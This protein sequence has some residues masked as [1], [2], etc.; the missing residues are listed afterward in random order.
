M[1]MMS[2]PS[3]P[4]RE[5][6]RN[7]GENPGGSLSSPFRVSGL[8]EFELGS[9][10]S[11]SASAST[12]DSTLTEF[13]DRWQRGER[14]SAED[15]F[16]RLD[17][18]KDSEF[19]ELIYRE[20]C[21]A[22]SAGLEPDVLSFL[23]RFPAYCKPLNQLFSVHDAL[24]SSDLQSWFEPVPMPEVGC[25]LGPYLLVRELG[26]GGFARVFLAE[27]TD[28]DDRLVV[29][30]ISSRPSLEHKLLARSSH[31]NIVEVLWHGEV[32]NYPPPGHLHAVPGR[33][34]TV[35]PARRSEERNAAR[36][37]DGSLL[38]DLDRLSITG[39]Q[40]ASSARPS[41]RLI[42]GLSY[43]KSIGW[44][45]ARL[46]EA[47]DFA[48]GR[49][50]L[51]GDVKPSNILIAADGSPML[52]DFNM[53]VTWQP[54]SLVG[55]SDKS[56]GDPGGTLA[57]MAPERL[58]AIAK[59]DLAVPP[60]PAQR[61]RADIYSL[62]VVLYEALSGLST[63]INGGKG[64]TLQE[65]A[66]VYAS[67]RQPG[68]EV[69]IRSARSSLPV[70]LRP[71]LARCL[72]PDLVD[73]YKRASELA[74]DLDRW[75]E[76]QPLTHASEP[77]R[78]LALARWVRRQHQTLMATAL[79]VMVVAA[80]GLL[81]WRLADARDGRQKEAMPALLADR[82]QRGL[83]P[84]S[85]F[86]V[87]VDPVINPRA[88]PAELARR[89]LE[90]YGVLQNKDWRLQ[91]DVRG[92]PDFERADLEVWLLEQALRYAD[93]LIARPNA[94]TAWQRALLCLENA[95]SQT[96]YGPIGD[97]SR[98]LRRLLHEAD[99]PQAQSSGR[100]FN[101][102][103]VDD[104][105]LGVQAELRGDTRTALDHFLRVLK[106]R[107]TSF[108]ANYRAAAAEFKLRDFSSSS[109]HLWECVA[110]H[111]ENAVLRRQYAGC[112][113]SRDKHL[114]ADREYEKAKSLDPERPETYLSRAFL[115]ARMNQPRGFLSDIDS[116]EVLKG[117]RGRSST[118]PLSLSGHE[119]LVEDH[120]ER[121]DIRPVDW[122][123]PDLT[124]ARAGLA[125]EL[126]WRRQDELALEQFEKVLAAEPDKIDAHWG[127]AVALG[128]LNRD[129]SI[130]EYARVVEHPQVE[131]W[132]RKFPTAVY[133]FEYVATQM[134][135]NQQVISAIETAK[136]GSAFG[137]LYKKDQA[138][139]HFVLA[140]AYAHAS[141]DDSSFTRLVWDELR[142][143]KS[144]GDEKLA[145]WLASDPV[146]EPY[147][148]EM[149]S[150][151]CP[152]R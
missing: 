140:R 145:T 122:L 22:E 114:E 48:Y 86:V 9:V 109:E 128:R 52:L 81:A 84:R 18:N 80:G 15:Y 20:Y 82:R 33:N 95:S 90:S 148:I 26:R 31:P 65:I 116:F 64:L 45:V 19:V 105:L 51:H 72:A 93:A 113:L 55:S 38:A 151:Q 63:E 62:G 127:R 144:F 11:H 53:A 69:M 119:S 147:R 14:P 71:I 42:E 41:R 121:S 133:A 29:V 1:A 23:G 103:W 149:A 59:P 143:A 37:R 131:A 123:D 91:N 85:W 10:S 92:L 96:D 124:L 130:Q 24:E 4:G 136:R 61:H 106:D 34:D 49:N 134:I 107:P 104:Y 47:L 36:P 73:R 89:H 79:A 137:D 40:S 97:R 56:P 98:E 43:A 132:T 16:P 138:R 67:S 5:H 142:K 74:D 3:W 35:I 129:G 30:K 66:S 126:L 25:A 150:S 115:H 152:G 108:W 102:L 101:G 100:D 12:F 77:W 6:A 120:L 146:L 117:L 94:P 50:V 78:R 28:L 76:D 99:P 8:S 141:R 110:Q 46:A 7:R 54:S 135:D 27:Q 60:S 39:Y 88:E 21:M 58:R 57:Y 125:K 111:P 118:R 87:S 70:G 44:F 68:G 83:G 13:T 17:P 112:L 139:L 32:E 75:R 2:L